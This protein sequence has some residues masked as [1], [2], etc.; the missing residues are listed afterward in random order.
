MLFAFLVRPGFLNVDLQPLNIESYSGNSHS[1]WTLQPG[2]LRDSFVFSL[3]VRPS[4]FNS[5]GIILFINS[6]GDY[7]SLFLTDGYVT[8]HLHVG[9]DTI[10]EAVSPQRISPNVFSAI[11]VEKISNRVELSVDSGPAMTGT[12]IG[13]F[14]FLNIGNNLY[15]GGVGSTVVL[16]GGLPGQG[17]YGC[18]ADVRLNGDRLSQLQSGVSVRE[19]DFDPC[20]SN[21][22]SNDT[23]CMPS[24]LNYVCTHAGECRLTWDASN[25]QWREKPTYSCTTGVCLCL[26]QCVCL[27]QCLCLRAGVG[28]LFHSLGCHVLLTVS[29]SLPSSCPG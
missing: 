8:V 9:S 21:T 7:F 23:T 16:P 25:E 19:C 27:C 5:T 24:G 11:T 17:L 1:L 13:P 4:D 10:G 15:V 26:C 12:A 28:A 22:C 29:C 14:T 20:D 6:Q 2:S 3:N 18:V